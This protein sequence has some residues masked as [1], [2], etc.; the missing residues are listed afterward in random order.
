MPTKIFD[1]TTMGAN[2][3]QSGDD[4][5]GIQAAID[6]ATKAGK[7]AMAYLPAGTYNVNA[8][9]KVSGADFWIGGAGLKTVIEMR[10]PSKVARGVPCPSLLPVLQVSSAKNVSI[11]MLS[12]K[13]PTGADHL[14]VV[15]GSG[16]KYLKLDGIYCTNSQTNTESWNETGA[17]HI[18]GL[19]SG[20]TVHA[21]H[22]DGNVHVTDSEPGTFLVGMLIQS[23]LHMTAAKKATT[24]SAA[25]A[26][27]PRALTA[28]PPVGFLTFIG[29]VDDY[30]LV[31]EDDK[32]VVIEDLYCEQLK[33]SP[34]LLSTIHILYERVRAYFSPNSQLDSLHYHYS[35]HKHAVD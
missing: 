32:S 30:D 21:I 34:P 3:S 25:V 9:L 27:A 33:V 12:I 28:G 19:A 22:L 18:D 2:G 23:T 5:A 7:G 13:A 24:T 14:H 16:I 26:A 1:V 11:E 15:G 17:I 31:I 6:A 29:L 10:C 35:A 20:E 4:T 8:T